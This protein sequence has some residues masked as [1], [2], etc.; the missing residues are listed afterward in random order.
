MCCTKLSLT[1]VWLL[2]VSPLGSF[3]K[4]QC[5]NEAHERYTAEMYDLF[6]CSAPKSLIYLNDYIC[7]T[8][9]FL[10]IRLTHMFKLPPAADSGA[11]L[12]ALVREVMHNVN[13]GSSEGKREKCCAAIWSYHVSYTHQSLGSLPDVFSHRASLQTMKNVE[14]KKKNSYSKYSCDRTSATGSLFPCK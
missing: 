13:P 3:V 1:A 5:V 8:A 2:P 12:N 10:P 11:V 14:G 9:I 6:C 4:S 7:E